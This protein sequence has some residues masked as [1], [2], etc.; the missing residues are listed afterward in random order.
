MLTRWATKQRRRS[1]GTEPFPSN[2][3]SQPQSQYSGGSLISCGAHKYFLKCSPTEKII[4]W[5]DRIRTSFIADVHVQNGDVPTVYWT[6]VLRFLFSQ[7]PLKWKQRTCSSFPSMNFYGSRS[8]QLIP[9]LTTCG[10]FQ[11]AAST[12]GHYAHG[13][14]F[15]I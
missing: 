1:L 5:E 4:Y 7:K 13:C 11:L 8:S 2:D 9:H 14:P 6:S 15:H 10:W 3:P 12:S